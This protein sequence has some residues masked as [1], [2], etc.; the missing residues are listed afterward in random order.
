MSF[1]FSFSIANCFLYASIFYFHPSL[2]FIISSTK[3]I[4]AIITNDM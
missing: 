3:Q 2:I 4:D 1:V